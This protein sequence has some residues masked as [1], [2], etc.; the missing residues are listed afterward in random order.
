MRPLSEMGVVCRFL[1][2]R[3][4]RLILLNLRLTSGFSPTMLSLSPGAGGLLLIP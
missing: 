4:R 1:E 3:T 2:L